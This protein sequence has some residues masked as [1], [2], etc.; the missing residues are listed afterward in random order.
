MR[1]PILGDSNAMKTA[2]TLSLTFLL[3]V[4]CGRANAPRG[5]A[6]QGAGACPDAVQKSVVSA[7]AD[8][9]IKACKLEREDGHDQYEVK[10]QQGAQPVEVD[11]A[12]EGTILQV[13][14]VIPVNEAPPKVMAAFT[15]KYPGVTC[16]RV[17]KQVRTGKGTFYELKIDTQPKAKE[18]TFAEDGSFV[19]EE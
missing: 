14:T 18:I 1:G 7:F 11:V 3:A 10:L 16:S 8:A 19:E 12:P 17:E 4:A 2:V 9:A 5:D 15:A 13:E 6:T